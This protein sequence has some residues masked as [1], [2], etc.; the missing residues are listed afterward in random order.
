MGKIVLAVIG[1]VWGGAV[2]A[3]AVLGSGGFDTGGGAGY[4]TGQFMAML[5]AAA[6]FGLCVRYLWLHAR[7]DR[8]APAETASHPTSHP[9]SR[10]PP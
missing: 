4:A 1:A 6:V 9:A 3:S 7:G 8:Q 2:L 5:V 10:P